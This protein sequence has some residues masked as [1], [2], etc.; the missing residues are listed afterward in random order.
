MRNKGLIIPFAL[1]KQVLEKIHTGHQGIGK[2]RERA[3]QTVWW[4]GLSSE[5]EDAVGKCRT[6]CMNQA[7]KTE[8]MI[9]ST[10]LELPWQKVGMDQYEWKKLAY[11]IIM[12]LQIYRDS[13]ARQSNG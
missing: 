11:L 5:I 4:P 3:G 12:E 1:Q 8:P 9:P 10:L 7:Q 6:C 13:K 2:C